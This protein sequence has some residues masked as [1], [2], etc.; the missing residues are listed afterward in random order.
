MLRFLGQLLGDGTYLE[1]N[2]QFRLAFREFGTCL[3]IGC[4]F[5]PDD[6]SDDADVLKNRAEAIISQWEEYSSSTVTPEELRPITRVMFA[7]ALIPGGKLA[8][9]QTRA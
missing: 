6:K 1:T 9:A 3:G 2:V 7:T 8:G 5:A 4:A